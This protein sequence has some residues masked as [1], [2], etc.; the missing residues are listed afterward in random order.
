MRPIDYYFQR[1]QAAA[2]EEEFEV[3]HEFRSD[4]D[5]SFENLVPYTISLLSR[6][7]NVVLNKDD[8]Q[9][10]ARKDALNFVA[11]YFYAFFQTHTLP[12]HDEYIKLLAAVAFFFS[13]QLGSS[14][15]LSRMVSDGNLANQCYLSL[16][17]K[18][19]MNNDIDFSVDESKYYAKELQNCICSFKASVCSTMSFDD[20]TIYILRSL[21]YKQ[22][23]DRDVLMVDLIC[24]I[25]LLKSKN[26]AYKMLSDY[27]D[28]PEDS[29]REMIGA[30]T[31]ITEFWPA[32][33][34]LARNG[35]FQGGSGIV[36]LPTGAGKTKSI[37]LCIFSFLFANTVGVSIVIAP[38][39]ALCREISADLKRAFS[40][41]PDIEIVEISD[42]LQKDYDDLIFYGNNKRNVVVITPEK[43]MF[44]L[45][46]DENIASSIG[47]IIFDEGH[48]FEDNT[49]G[50]NYELLISLLLTKTPASTQR[51][52]ISAI[53]GEVDSLNSWL[54]GGTGSVIEN[55]SFLTTKKNAV[56]LRLSNLRREVYFGFDYLNRDNMDNY[57]YYVPRVI[58]QIQLSD[59]TLFPFNPE[60]LSIATAL[61]LVTND[62]CIMF[63][64]VRNR[65]NKLM[66]RIVAL[67]RLGLD[68][69]AL[70]ERNNSDEQTKIMRLIELEYGNTSNYYEAARDGVFVHHAQISDGIK[71]CLEYAIQKSDISC[72]ICT[73]TLSQGVNMRIKHMIICSLQL[74]DGWISQRDFQN[75]IGRVGRPGMY[76]EGN[77]FY[78]DYIAYNKKTYRWKKFKSL[79]TTN[80]SICTSQLWRLCKEQKIGDRTIIFSSYILFYYENDKNDE[81]IIEQLR[82]YDSEHKAYEGKWTDIWEQTKDVLNRLESFV[83]SFESGDYIPDFINKSLAGQR[84]NTDESERLHLVISSVYSYV[85]RALISVES[86]QLYSKSLMDVQRYLS[87]AKDVDIFVS[88]N[89]MNVDEWILY[90]LIQY[91]EAKV[92]RKVDK[93]VLVKIAELWVSGCS[94]AA[95]LKHCQENHYQII[96]RK[97]PG[98]FTLEE[99]IEICDRG[100]GYSS[101]IV[102][103][104][105]LLLLDSR[106]DSN[107]LIITRIKEYAAQLKYGLPNLKDIL[108]YEIGI[109]DRSVV[110]ELSSLISV[111]CSD[112]D[113]LISI[114]QRYK[115]IVVDTLNQYPKYFLNN[116]HNLIN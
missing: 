115:E 63:C 30:K 55:D 15:V 110:M 92:I 12:E 10:L 112:K 13:E 36:Q 64:G 106:S 59:G 83:A 108:L 1:T 29:I 11:E 75:L 33:T 23:S 71:S 6:T 114:L 56:A 88:D 4:K 84:L 66:E 94:Y 72:L 58:K 76:I 62:N 91:G 28:V 78:T 34:Y 105:I 35:F 79:W 85:N 47:Q 40:Y 2:R 31:I 20:E 22:G 111:D 65:A 70:S 39:R 109:N 45:D 82:L 37:S 48:L 26:S 61:R 107:Q 49:R 104:S 113:E 19:I 41:S 81:R 97:N 103:N 93:N 116:I 98:Q 44:V 16:V 60:D 3:P 52:L 17:L 14:Q 18:K 9:L 87:V 86:R 46:Q 54:T 67:K 77:V 57:D 51:I 73:S 100:F 50:T 7:A 101:T 43:L 38:F 5:V 32:Q 102:I 96:K 24:A 42:L 99:I 95:I 25:I 69:S 80:N 8:D 68:I 90:M 74:G 27:S 89:M 21:V 53:I